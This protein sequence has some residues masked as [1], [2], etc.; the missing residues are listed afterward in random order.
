MLATTIHGE[1]SEE[2]CGEVD[3]VEE[4]KMESNLG[5]MGIAVSVMR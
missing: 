4:K 3:T 5:R 1:C 2:M